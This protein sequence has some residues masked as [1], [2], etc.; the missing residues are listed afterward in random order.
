MGVRE[1]IECYIQ[2][3]PRFVFFRLQDGDRWPLGS[4]GVPVT[5]LRSLATDKGL[6]PR[7]GVTLVI[8]EVPVA[9]GGKRR[10]EQ[11]MLDQDAGG[12][13]NTP[14]RADIYYGVGGEAGKLAG[15][16]YAEGR[17]YY[18]FLKADRL[19][20]WQDRLGY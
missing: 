4:L 10:L 5:P 2:R 3:N 8:T 16:Q 13:I 17:L 7:G 9:S 6:F 14:G 19:R 15:G 18:L 11:F 1:D 12:A 20:R